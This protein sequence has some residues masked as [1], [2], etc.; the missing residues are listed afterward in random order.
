MEKQHHNKNNLNVQDKNDEDWFAETLFFKRI[1]F[2]SIDSTNTWAKKNSSQWLENGMTLITAKE[3][4]AGRG[5]FNRI[6][7]SPPDDNIYASFCFWID[8]DRSD[9]GHI[10]Q[11]LALSL[12]Q[13]LSKKSFAPQIKWPNDILLSKKKV[14][15]ILCETILEN[16]KRGVICGIGINVNMPREILEQIDRP[17]TSLLQESGKKG[18]VTEIL[19]NLQL[20][21]INN[22]HVFL[23]EGF[24]P[25]FANYQELLCHKQGDRVRFHNNQAIV[26]GYFESVHSDGSVT[27]RF[28][29]GQS[30][31]FF[32]GEFLE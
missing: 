31:K 4:T 23:N 20:Q 24:K 7:V 13:I 25:F 6:W 16:N 14:G 19:A 3:Q 1:H 5:R 17:A 22:L 15:G 8:P 29:D 11:L 18:D 10:P 26:E 12:T 21:F 2:K 32:S 9:I 28:F 27:L 30:Q